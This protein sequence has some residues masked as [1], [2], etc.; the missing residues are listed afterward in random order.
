M[1]QIEVGKFDSPEPY[2]YGDQ[3]T[4]D[5]GA[6]FLRDCAWVEDWGCGRGFFRE[7]IRRGRYVGVDMGV[8]SVSGDNPFAAT[9]V[10]L[11][12][13]TSRAPGIFMRHVLEHNWTWRRI[14]LNAVMS[15]TERMMLVIFTPL[16]PPESMM[17]EQ[18]IALHGPPE[19]PVYQ[20]PVPN[21]SFRRDA[22]EVHFSSA[23]SFQYE[24][25]E[26]HTQYGGE[27]V[28]RLTK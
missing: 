9:V 19:Y 12:H 10:A 15:F 24:Y 16:L 11:E 21:L 28:W 20:K 17:D 13:Y 26:T 7:F 18:V 2:P 27:H 14:L 8:D 1:R 25:Y 6:Q 5:L 23:C 3:K 22:I 4:Y